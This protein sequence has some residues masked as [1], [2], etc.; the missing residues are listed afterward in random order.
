MGKHG[1]ISPV[2][3]CIIFIFNIRNLF[4]ALRIQCKQIFDVPFM[5]FYNQSGAFGEP[6]IYYSISKQKLM[7]YHLLIKLKNHIFEKPFKS[8]C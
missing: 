8:I 3:K 4:D 5:N 7:A 1:C 6:N 2:I